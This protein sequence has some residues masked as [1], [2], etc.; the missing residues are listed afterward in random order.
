[1]TV[2]K[3]AVVGPTSV[4]AVVMTA[5]GNGVGTATVL[6]RGALM[7]VTGDVVVGLVGAR[8]KPAR[9]GLPGHAGL[10]SGQPVLDPGV[11]T[12]VGNGAGTA[13][14]L[15]LGDPKVMVGGG[16]AGLTTKH[17]SPHSSILIG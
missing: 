15:G 6:G 9:D 17:G 10:T 3:D 16:M 1:M 14:G 7:V 11:M 13:M 4:M 8:R 12:A 5:V 2:V